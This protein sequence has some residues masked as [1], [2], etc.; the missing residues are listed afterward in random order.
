MSHVK[1]FS[2]A[3]GTQFSRSR[4][5]RHA[6]RVQSVGRCFSS[7][8][9]QIAHK[10]AGRARKPP[11]STEWLP[12]TVAHAHNGQRFPHTD[13]MNFVDCEKCNQPAGK[14][15]TDHRGKKLSQVHPERAEAYRTR[16]KDRDELFQRRGGSSRQGSLVQQEVT[17]IISAE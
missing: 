10:R 3:C 16:F 17:Q 11:R 2:D 12:V 6:A 15:C 4:N 13:A 14:V 7:V 1:T 9:S 5:S 8:N